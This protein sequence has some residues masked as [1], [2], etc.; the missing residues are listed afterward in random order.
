MYIYSKY[1]IPRVY[2]Y[3]IF[4]NLQSVFVKNTIYI[5]KYK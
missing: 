4:K 2:L 3:I 1:F 5:V